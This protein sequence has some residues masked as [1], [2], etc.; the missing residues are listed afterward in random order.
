MTATASLFPV[1]LVL[2]DPSL[3]DM[4]LLPLSSALLPPPITFP[5]PL[6]V[7]PPPVVSSAV[8]PPLVPLPPVPSPPVPSPDP[9]GVE[10]AGVP[11][12][13][14]R[15]TDCDVVCIIE[16]AFWDSIPLSF[17]AVNV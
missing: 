10:M 5:P 8:F 4:V 12:D 11:W 2:F 7:P 6:L 9:T 14:V 1:P 15:I 17:S 3:P 16:P 13:T